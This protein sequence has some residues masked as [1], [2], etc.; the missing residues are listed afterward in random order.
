MSAS[1]VNHWNLS[2]RKALVSG[3]A[4]G[5]GRAIAGEFA[6]LGA[7]VLIVARDEQILGD[8]IAEWLRQNLAVDGI[9]VDVS[10]GEDR[11]AIIDV[12]RE[13]W[14][15]LDILVN[16]VGTN[17]RKAA[18]QFSAD[19]IRRIFEINL[20]SAFELSRMSY[21]F[22]R[23][24]ENSGIVNIS[25][26]AGLTH[27][28]TGA[29]YGMT[30]A[31]M[32]QMTRNLAVEWAKDGIR[33]NCIAPWY[34]RTPLAEQVLQ[35]E[36]YLKAVLQRTPLG[37]VGEPEEVAGLAA[38]LCMPLAAYITGQCIAVDGGFS[39]FGF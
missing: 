24:G 3:G 15:N 27:L 39:V 29:I 31:A 20:F 1:T 35:N 23:D 10:H 30:K 8:T 16:N 12:V 11:L 25:S 18:T 26:V 19:V 2:N 36:A 6:R 38:F 33:I 7:E 28:S 14:G 37:R 21:P 32:A 13:S 22:L 17:I 34:I 9:V 4:K 5:I